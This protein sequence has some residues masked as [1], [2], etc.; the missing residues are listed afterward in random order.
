MPAGN[1]LV[2]E[3]DL[4]RLFAG[5]SAPALSANVA[6]GAAGAGLPA[7]HGFCVEGALGNTRAGVL[8]SQL[9]SRRVDSGM[10]K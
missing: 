6:P 8:L 3:S 1:G 4:A 10:K 9:A 2:G 7:N 5:E